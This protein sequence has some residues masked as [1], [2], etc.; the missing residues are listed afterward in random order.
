LP[1]YFL[2]TSAFAKRYLPESGSAWLL[3][4]FDDDDCSVA[5]SAITAVELASA[6]AGAS[7][8]GEI[9]DEQR[10]T[11]YRQFVADAAS[12]EVLDASEGLLSE[13]SRLLLAPLS[14]ALRSLDAIQLA[15][16][17]RWSERLN[18]H[19]MG[20]GTFV[21]ADRRLRDGAR[22]LGIAVDNPEE[23]E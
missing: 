21:V 20:L 6:L 3:S 5:I 14:V 1:L 11:Q 18:A 15:T 7:R 23:H 12:L 9:T 4:L 13:A 19:N 8:R 17:I 10:D 2:D 16:A 22:E